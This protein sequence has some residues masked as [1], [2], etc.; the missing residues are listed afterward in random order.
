MDEGS[1]SET[2]QRPCGDSA[3]QPGDASVEDWYASF[4]WG[5]G[6]IVHVHVV[7]W[8]RG[9]PR[10]DVV[11]KPDKDGNLPK[12]D[13]EAKAAA[14]VVLDEDLADIMA[15]FNDRVYTEWNTRKA[16]DG[17]E[18]ARLGERE[19][20]RRD[21]SERSVRD[22]CSIP[23]AELR[24][25]LEAGGPDG[26][27]GRVDVC[28]S[29]AEWCNM[30]DWHV[31]HP[32]GPQHTKQSCARVLK[33]TEGTS[34][35]MCYC[36]KL[37][38]R[39]TRKPGE[40][41]IAEDPHRRDLYRVWLARNC[42]FMNNY[43]PLLLVAPLA[44]IDIQA[45]TSRFAVVQ[46]VTKYMTK[47]GKGTLL[48]QA[49]QAFDDALGRALENGKGV[50]AAVVRFF[51][52]QVAP[53][54]ISQLE[55]HHILWGFP[56]YL[57][58]RSFTRLSLNVELKRLRTAGEMLRGAGGEDDGRPLTRMS[59]LE[60]YENRWEAAMPPRAIPYHWLCLRV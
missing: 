59:A 12:P 55:V 39:E 29:L 1:D 48:G 52:Q 3:G 53:R 30:H 22:P 23:W 25:V 15:S 17:S 45:V 43:H 4:E 49:E 54:A 35:E 20:R 50:M 46:Y 32:N 57:A 41:C 14:S 37:F 58:S 28:V 47:T 11:L 33:E 2:N 5:A 56:P 38:P 36:G 21:G 13:G 42:R 31:P 24:A 9:A 51:N 40:E 7:L 18:A 34:Q 6:G 19:R 8:V 27:K 16:N 44:N 60:Q 10:I 26:G